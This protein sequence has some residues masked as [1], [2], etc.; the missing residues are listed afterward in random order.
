MSFRLLEVQ[1]NGLCM[2]QCE[3]CGTVHKDTCAQNRYA[4]YRE[5]PKYCTACTHDLQAKR[6]KSDMSKQPDYSGLKTASVAEIEALPLSAFVVMCRRC[7]EVKVAESVGFCDSCLKVVNS[8]RY[9]MGHANF[10]GSV[11]TL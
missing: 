1:R 5:K 2:I 11:I 4:S 10:A 8:Y 3:T 6:Q 7:H 9:R